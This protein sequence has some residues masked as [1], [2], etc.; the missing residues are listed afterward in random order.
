MNF[1]KKFKILL[2]LIP[3]F[4][5]NCISSRDVLDSYSKGSVMP[6]GKNKKLKKL[7]KNYKIEKKRRRKAFFNH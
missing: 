3:I 6:Y 1:I 7:E 5:S 2:I 4:L